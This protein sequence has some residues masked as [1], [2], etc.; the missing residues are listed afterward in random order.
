M[1]I[2]WREGSIVGYL[3]NQSLILGF[4]GAAVG[5]GISYAL[6]LYLI[7]ILTPYELTA[8]GA[9]VSL[10]LNL[11]YFLYATLLALFF[12]VFAFAITYLYYRRLTPLKM[13]ED[14]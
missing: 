7:G 4:S 13:L 10:V 11:S 5:M 3:F 8:S 12:S 1:V 9:R 6:G 14:M 2:G